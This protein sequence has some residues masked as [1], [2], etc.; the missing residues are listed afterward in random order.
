MNRPFTNFQYR[1]FAVLLNVALMIFATVLLTYAAPSAIKLIKL[2][3]DIF[4]NPSSQHATEVEPDTYASGSTFVTAFQAGRFSGGGSSDIGYA[5]SN[6]AGK[7]WTH[8]FLP[9]ITQ[10]Y[11]GGTFGAAS[12]PAVIF[13][14]KHG[15]WLISSLGL[16]SS[17]VVLSSSSKD[18]INWNNPVTIDNTSTYADKDWI[19]CD[20]TAT[21]KF[22][23][24]CYVEWEDAGN[25]DQIRMSTSKDGGQT[26][27]AAFDVSGAI[28]LGGQ[29]V[30]QNTGK[31]VVPYLAGNNIGF[32]TSNNGGTTW[33]NVGTISNIIS[34]HVAGNLRAVYDLP[35]AE[36]DGAGNVYVT[37]W[38]CRF[39]SGCPSNDIVLSTSSNGTK[40]TAPSRVPIDAINS[41]VDHFLMGIAADRTTSGKTAHL[42]L[43][44][45]FYPNANCDQNTCKLTAGFVSSKD[46]GKTW[47]AP[48]T[49]TSAM[50]LNWLPST[51]LGQMVGDYISTSYVN[52]KAFGVFAEAF[53]NV[54]SKFNEAMYTPAVGM[55]EEENGPYFS[56]A[57]ERPVA[58]AKSDHGPVPFYDSEGLV[59]RPS[60]EQ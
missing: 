47:T 21:S 24:H 26:W 5:T 6:D 32:Y 29:P 59:P 31:V 2:S 19:T 27:S 13:D 43:T 52:G 33:G 60:E 3:T 55:I 16:G 41:T 45:Y 56:S 9:G 18:G 15:M 1:N 48:K 34:H 57:G 42:G 49:L 54:G 25:G 11:K 17:N 30:V 20:N 4:K 12:D 22:Y 28:G 44:Y 50:N 10:F 37:W 39:R 53:K 51:A 36:V 35:S 38:D 14:A 7:T 58:G 46:G 23:G 8:G 40:W